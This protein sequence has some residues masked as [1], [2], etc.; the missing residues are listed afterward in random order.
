MSNN[1]KCQNAPADIAQAIEQAEVIPDVLPSPD[2]FVSPK[3]PEP[4]RRAI[5]ASSVKPQD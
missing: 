5:S 3:N 4:L 1:G 2:Q